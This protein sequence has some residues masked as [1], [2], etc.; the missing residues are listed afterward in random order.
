MIS[1][2]HEARESYSGLLNW[3]MARA[4]I[5]MHP[6]LE[7][8]RRLLAALGHPES[9]VRMVQVAGTNGKG[10]TCRL[11]QA[12]LSAHGWRT[13]LF[14][15]PHIVCLRERFIIGDEAVPE[16]ECAA[17]LAEI[18]PAAE[19]VNASFF[20]ICTALAVLWFRRREVDFAVM[21]TGLGG[22]FDSVTALPAEALLLTGASLDHTAILG[23]TVE[24]IW[25]EKVAAL[26][27]GRPVFTPP[28]QESL[29][30]ILQ[31]RAGAEGSRV[32]CCREPAPLNPPLAG[33]GQRRNLDLAWRAAAFLL[34]R[35]PDAAAVR[36]VFTRLI[37]P[38]R[39]QHLAGNPEVVMDVGHNPEALGLVT[40]EMAGRRPV[41]LFACMADKD[42]PTGLAE[43]VAGGL[44]GIHLFPLPTARAE[45]PEN[46][47][48]RF[49]EAKLHGSAAAAWEAAT[50]AARAQGVPVLVCGS[51][52]TVEAV[53]RHLL[54][55]GH[56]A[57]WPEGIVPDPE[58]PG[59]G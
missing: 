13:G 48:A 46:I 45:R 23:N 38:G 52:R 54:E 43:L 14:T 10:S 19:V 31:E 8:M 25:G 26:R 6:G 5:G 40:A 59:L 51:F 11:L 49:P 56:Y 36:R 42:W 34:G 27:P 18:R 35:E 50:E 20:E 21:E 53:Q 15:S 55:Q 24:A 16:A 57:F 33:P 30:R 4:Q 2:E 32:I 3:M 17:L 9:G 12:V 28:Q 41:L 39:L 58:V 1:E 37:W 47:A 44:S 7:T 29:M 22:R